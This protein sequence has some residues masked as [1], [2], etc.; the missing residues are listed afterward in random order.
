MDPSEGTDG[1]PPPLSGDFPRPTERAAP[2]PGDDPLHADLLLRV[3]DAIRFRY[4]TASVRLV[5]GYG[6]NPYLDVVDQEDGAATRRPVAVFVG[7]PDD[8]TVSTFVGSVLSIYQRQ[9]PLADG[10]LVYSGDPPMRDV[11][12]RARRLGVQLRSLVEIEG[13]WDPRRYLDRQHSALVRDRN[14]PP[15]QYVAQRYQRFD[16]PPD[17]PP[18]PDACGAIVDWLDTHDPRLIL[19]LGDPGM[20]KT[21]LAHELARRVPEQLPRLVPMLI[22]LRALEKGH[23]LDT[24]LALHLQQAGEDGISVRAVRR[25]I[26]Q[27]HLLL[28][29]DGFDELAMRLTYDAAADH[30][31]TLLSA[32]TGR[33]KVVITSRTQHF[34]SDRQLSTALGDMVTLIPAARVIRL[35]GFDEAAFREY[36]TRRYTKTAGVPAASVDEAAE[37]RLS[38]IASTTDLRGLVSSPRMLAF[39]A[40]LPETDL[41]A[42]RGHDGTITSAHL[43]RSLVERWLS[44]EVARRRPYL[45]STPSLSAEQLWTVV[46]AVA[47]RMWTR[48]ENAVELSTLAATINDVLP[49]LGPTALDSAQTLFAVGSGSLLTRDETDRFAFVHF[50]VAEHLVAAAVADQLS[51]GEEPGLLAVR[52]ASSLLIDFLVGAAPRQELETWVRRVLARPAGEAGRPARRRR[53]APGVPGTLPEVLRL[54][55]LAVGGRLGLRTMALNLAGQDLRT[56]DLSGRDLRFANLSGANLAGLRLTDLD[57]TGADLSSADLAGVTLTRVSLRD[58]NLRSAFLRGATLTEVDLSLAQLAGSVWD[59]AAV[60]G[61]TLDDLARHAPELAA[62]A[63]PGRDPTDLMVLPPLTSLARVAWSPAGETIAVAWG[64]HVVLV[65]AQDLRPTRV[66][67][68]GTAPPRPLAFSPDGRILASGGD[69]RVLRL[70]DAVTGHPVAALTGHDAPIRAIAFAPGGARVASADKAGAIHIW[71]IDTRRPSHIFSGHDGPVR[72]L[73]FSLDGTKLVSAGDDHPPRLWDTASGTLLDTLDRGA[74]QIRSVAFSPDGTTIAYP[75]RDGTISLWDVSA[76]RLTRVLIWQ[77]AIVSAVDFFHDGTTLAA[78]ND[79]GSIRLWWVATETPR[80]S[81]AGHTNA[82]RSVALSPDDSQVVSVGKDGSLRLWDALTGAQRASLSGHQ[83]AVRSVSFT[84]AGRELVVLGSDGTVRLWNT[85]SGQQISYRAGE[86]DTGRPVNQV[87]ALA[88]AEPAIA[89]VGRDHGVQFPKPGEPGETLTLAG[90]CA[91]RAATFTPDG[92]RLATGDARAVRIWDTATGEELTSITVGRGVRA[93]AISADG[94]SVAAASTDGQVRLWRDGAL[95]VSVPAHLSAVRALAVGPDHTLL[96]SANADGQITLWELSTGRRV[97]TLSGHAEAVTTL[98]FAPTGRLLASGGED[99]TVRLWNV[100]TFGTVA[101]FLP[102]ERGRWATI[103]PNGQFLASDNDG[104]DRAWYA[105]KGRRFEL[106]GIDALTGLA[107]TMTGSAA[108][109]VTA[110]GLAIAAPA[111]TGLVTAAPVTAPADGSA[112][113]T[114]AVRE[115][116]DLLSKAFDDLRPTNRPQLFQ[117]G[118]VWISDRAVSTAREIEEFGGEVR[119][120]QVGYFIHQEELSQDA[121]AAT[122]RLRLAGLTIVTV[123]YRALRAA[124]TDGWERPFLRELANR[125]GNGDNLFETRNSLTERRFLFGRSL[126]LNTI[127]SALRRGEQVLV[128]GLRKIGK[129]SLLNILRQDLADHPVC[130]LD[131]QQFDRHGEQW[132]PAVFAAVVEA[133]D[134]WAATTT[135]SWSFAPS[136]P[137]TGS[138]LRSEIQRRRDE[139]GGQYDPH[140]IV[141]MDELETVFPGPDQDL[142]IREWTRAMGALRALAQG[143]DRLLSI[144]GADLRPIA[145]RTNLLTRGTNPFFSLFKEVPLPLLDRAAIG[146]MVESIARAMAVDSVAPAF[147]EFLHQLSGGHPSLARTVAAEAYRRRH[148]PHRLTEADLRCGVDDDQSDRIGFVVRDN[149]WR[150]MTPDEKET[151]R[152]LARR[153][154]GWLRRAPHRS[155]DPAAQAAHAALTEQGLVSGG[156]ITV[157]LLEQ[158]VRDQGGRA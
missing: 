151:V 80:V 82:V 49:G 40:D 25:M 81:L 94:A 4:P 18:R 21:F 115:I 107:A 61:G 70:W 155:G 36:L 39:V 121:E 84:T 77:P 103:L 91:V 113:L 145:N 6:T 19:V 108:N 45:A 86:V 90:T 69:D 26:D 156:R 109:L 95:M 71:D 136:S 97:A 116:V 10:D 119:V 149:L 152:R 147:V 96:A 76:S 99:G 117:P 128:T 105:V 143:E 154:S 100:T 58:A 148:D 133:F 60:L 158:W 74:E 140:I 89:S 135:D 27:G 7:T 51:R 64:N 141:I 55:A 48:G 3:Q 63:I 14:Y 56:V 57:L 43:Y 98:A 146:E 142:A 62:A 16:E 75:G 1:A 114:P 9:G 66:L 112:T 37:R 157:G 67:A 15:E 144:I 42:A 130:F 78:G 79:A 110:S 13:G 87:V 138:R 11:V 54:N 22:G 104:T 132:A 44:Y 127:G 23:S 88:S 73:A 46:T 50:S 93:V 20:G 129:T 124:V 153:R 134:R 85:N 92:T 137:D 126:M 59:G 29:F 120:G 122:D 68:A 5:T 106:T 2:S 53:G 32:V 35:L 33:A 65:A 125:H 52:A 139:L 102:L 72:A 111:S 41:L 34:A 12:R 30:L 118:P 150:P 17:S 24:I 31:R 38:L 101:M 123:S 83:E 47:V 8:E 131:M 28:I